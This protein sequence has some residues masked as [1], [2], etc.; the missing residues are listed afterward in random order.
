[1][2][3]QEW[4]CIACY[5]CSTAI[6]LHEKDEEGGWFWYHTNP[7]SDGSVKARM[8]QLKSIKSSAIARAVDAYQLDADVHKVT[9]HFCQKLK[10]RVVERSPSRFARAIRKG[11]DA[12]ICIVV[13]ISNRRGYS[14]YVTNLILERNNGFLP[15]TEED[16]PPQTG[17]QQAQLYMT[18]DELNAC[19]DP[20]DPR[21]KIPPSV[22]I[23]KNDPTWKIAKS[24]TTGKWF[25]YKE[26]YPSV[27]MSNEEFGT[28]PDTEDP[29]EK[30]TPVLPSDLISDGWGIRW[31][32]KYNSYVMSN[33]K[34]QKC[35]HLRFNSAVK[36]WEVD[37]G[38]RKPPPEWLQKL[39]MAFD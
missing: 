34:A 1:M 28:Y 6:P 22:E 38:K 21:G 27:Y 20:D 4:A 3:I 33:D 32:T 30:I 15:K 7:R 36:R 35:C 17:L 9:V 13:R 39:I 26:G 11:H 29:Q 10:N 12:N 24:K 19:P 23:I 18:K 5:V 14:S 2:L 8:A 31:N 25:F 16:I 37:P